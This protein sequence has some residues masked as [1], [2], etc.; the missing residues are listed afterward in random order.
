MIL[1][2]SNVLVFA[3]FNVR[4][5]R[6]TSGGRLVSWVFNVSCVTV[7]API[8]GSVVLYISL[9]GFFSAPRIRVPV[10]LGR[11]LRVSLLGWSLQCCL[12]VYGSSSSSLR[13]RYNGSCL[14]PRCPK[15]MRFPTPYRF[16]PACVHHPTLCY[17][18]L[19]HGKDPLPDQHEVTPGH[20]HYDT[21][22]K[23]TTQPSVSHA[24][25]VRRCCCN[26]RTGAAA[27]LPATT[28]SIFPDLTSTILVA[29]LRCLYL[30]LR[31]NKTF[32]TQRFNLSYPV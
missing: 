32:H 8:S 19:S 27:V 26:H 30:P 5:I 7:L 12:C 28:S 21:G 31:Q 15:H 29:H 23:G 25:I 16:A 14:R 10:R 1:G 2:F 20:K 18:D 4:P 13:A 24:T 11:P 3:L 17:Q 9:S 22:L 6:L